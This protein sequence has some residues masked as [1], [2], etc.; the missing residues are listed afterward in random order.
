MTEIN[1]REYR[2][3]IDLLRDKRRKSPLSHFWSLVALVLRVMAMMRFP[4]GALYVAF[5]LLTLMKVI[6]VLQ[7]GE[8]QYRARLASYHNPTLSER[9]AVFMMTPDGFTLKLRDLARP[10]I[11]SGH[12]GGSLAGRRCKIL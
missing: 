3:R 5:L 11:G 6:I 7:I 9:I 12:C 2:A 8:D 10:V 1:I 4:K